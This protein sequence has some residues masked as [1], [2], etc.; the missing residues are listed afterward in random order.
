MENIL[1]DFD[2]NRDERGSLVS[3]EQLKNIPFEMKRLYYIFEMKDNLPR[4]FHAHK[5]LLQVLVCLKGSCKVL[6]DNGKEKNEFTL[7]NPNQGLFI[8]HFLWREMYEFS[9]DCVLLVL[10]SEYYDEADYIRDYD[11]FL[12]QVNK[13]QSENLK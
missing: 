11:D 4:G 7:N 2:I 10:A 13:N 12:I 1:I 6:I 9:S 5:D 3:L 8:G